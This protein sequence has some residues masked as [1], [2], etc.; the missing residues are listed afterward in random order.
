MIT[1]ERIAAYID[2]LEKEPDALLR[3][4]EKEAL[5]DMIPIIKK[6]TQ[7]LLRFLIRNNKPVKILEV[8]AAVGYSSIFMSYYMEETAHI[9]TIEKMKER[10]ETAR[11][12][13]ERAGKEAQITLIEGDA[14][15]VLR[16]LK[17]NKE[18]Y[19]MIFMD[20]AKG[21]YF[22]FLPDVCAL[23]KTG[24]LL[25]SDNVLQD[26]DIVQSRYAVTR[27]DRT[28]HSRMREYLFTLT[29]SEEFDTVVL[30]IGD[31]VTLSTKLK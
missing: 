23:L 10:V 22:H 29:H 19:D 7:S 6:P 25:V 1:D 9:T 4:L 5:E 8:G 26:G 18:S 16:H 27:R 24:G 14:S 30:P 28:I 17:E 2:S 31:G 15:E 13:I 3:T 20:A 11:T 12:N 21:Q